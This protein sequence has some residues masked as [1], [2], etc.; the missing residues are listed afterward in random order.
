MPIQIYL[1]DLP[2]CRFDVTIKA[3]NQG[4]QIDTV[5]K[6]VYVSAVG[7]D[8]T[9]QVFP[10][11]HIDIGFSTLTVM[12]ISHPPTPITK[13]IFFLAT[14]ELV[15]TQDGQKW[16]EALKKHFHEFLE[17]RVKE[18]RPQGTLFVSVIVNNEPELRPYQLKKIEFYET[19]AQ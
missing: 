11:K 2:E 19:I 12:I 5:L 6:N 13:N 18:L 14:E 10:R 7:K 1:N 15:K 3:V 16:V 8:F 4:L 17:N 9:S